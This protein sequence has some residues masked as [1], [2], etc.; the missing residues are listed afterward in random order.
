[1]MK[2]FVWILAVSLLILSLA[3]CRAGQTPAAGSSGSGET[4]DAADGSAA[5]V[6]GEGSGGGTS[7]GVLSDWGV[8]LRVTQASA[9]GL[10][11]VWE[12]AGGLPEGELSTGTWY[13]VRRLEGGARTPLP[14][15][16]DNVGWD[17]VAI[18]LPEDGS[19]EGEADW[20][21][22]YGSLP[23]GEYEFVK[24]VMLLRAPG[25]YDK[26]EI[27]VPFTVEAVS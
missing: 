17:A 26:Q 25:D 5:P 11:Y 3:A 12:Q 15:Q 27:C 10:S 1:M 20:E 8:T 24:E 7:E 13:E 2:R 23:A 6:S 19:S 16:L 4:A 21:W 18:L 9:T 22:L 14:Y